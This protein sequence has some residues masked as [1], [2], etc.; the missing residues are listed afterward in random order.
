MTTDPLLLLAHSR[1]AELQ[2]AAR[3]QALVRLA[4]CCRPSSV[5]RSLGRLVAAVP[6]RRDA[7]CCA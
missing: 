3:T 7:V 1:S 4:T 5:R 6:R 2:A